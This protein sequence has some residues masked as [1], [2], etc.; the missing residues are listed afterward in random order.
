MPAFLAHVVTC[1]VL[2]SMA[3]TSKLADLRAGGLATSALR[4]HCLS[5]PSGRCSD[6]VVRPVFGLGFQLRVVFFDE[7]QDLL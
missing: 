7:L 3:A 5:A 6:T 4:D 2:G 1:R